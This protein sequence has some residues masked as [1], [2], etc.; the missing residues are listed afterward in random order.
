MNNGHRVLLHPI[1]AA[2]AALSLALACV[3]DARAQAAPSGSGAPSGSSGSAGAPG[4]PSGPTSTPSTPTSGS[5]GLGGPEGG[6]LGGP[7]DPNP[8]YI[9]V[10]QAFIHDSNVYRIPDGRAD[11]YSVTSLLGGFDQ[12]IGRQHVFARGVVSGNRYQDEKN[13]NNTSYSAYAGVDWETIENLSGNLNG[14]FNRSLTAAPT[15]AGVPVATQNISDT[16]TISALIRWGGPSLLSLEGGA[17]YSNVGYSSD[18]YASSEFNQ[19]SVNIGLFYHGGGPFRIGIGLRTDTTRTP[20]AFVDPATGQVQSTRL[21]GK[22]VDLTADYDVTGQVRADG[23]LSYTRQESS[24]PGQ[25]DFSGWTGNLGL[26]WQVTGKTFLRVDASR[27]AGFNAT[28]YNTFAFTETANGIAF[29][30]V[31]GVYQNNQLVSSAGISATW[32]ATAKISAFASARWQ[33]SHQVNVFVAPGT[34]AS[35]ITDVS[36]VFAL[37]ANYAITRNWGASCNMS[38]ERRDVSGG[39]NYAYNAKTF[40]CS[41]QYTWH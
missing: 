21:T 37:G 16:Q 13:L 26:A 36:D 20:Q 35:D 10:S 9:G 6:R 1:G 23:R 24:I 31:V 39:T 3:A 17:S 29:T 30:P 22:H 27:N 19:S 4:G 8:Y 38:Y 18:Q 28:T 25:E 14:S 41:T 15:N 11:T 5:G 7:S 32:A 34:P 40:G 33:R 12:T 2:A